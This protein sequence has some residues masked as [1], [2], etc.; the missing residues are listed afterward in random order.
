MILCKMQ[1]SHVE[2]VKDLLDSC[3]G[4]SAWSID[5]IRA[6]LD[7]DC[8]YCAVAVDEDK[9]VAYIAFEVITDEGSIVELAVDPK[10]RRMGMGRR[11][12][13][14]M[15]SSC[16]GVRTVCLEVRAS[17]TP[18]QALYRALDFQPITVRNNYYD[19]PREDAVIMIKKVK[20]EDSGY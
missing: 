15:L 18:A 7:K 2:G 16:S 4:D 10:H 5:S 9:V 1:P 6:Q 3:F 13:E 11:L 19:S 14:L 20:D 12:V 17:N 8:S